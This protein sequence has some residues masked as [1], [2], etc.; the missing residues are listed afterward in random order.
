V[1]IPGH[2]EKWNKGFSQGYRVTLARL[3]PIPDAKTGT[4]PPLDDKMNLGEFAS[5][6]KNIERN[7]AAYLDS[8]DK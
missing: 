4:H 3:L 1:P 5:G 8:P 6:L 2:S 7:R